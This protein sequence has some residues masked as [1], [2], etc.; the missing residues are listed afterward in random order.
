MIIEV[1]SKILSESLL[2]LYP[3]FVKKINIPFGLHLWCRFF[4]YVLVSFF[5]I[6][7]KFVFEHILSTN[8]ILLSLVTIMHVFFSYRGFQLL[9]SGI[10]Y[11][12]FYTYPIMILFLSGEKM[13]YITILFLF[14]AIF[15]IYLLYSSSFISSSSSSF[16][17]DFERKDENKETKEKETNLIQGFIMVFMAAFTEAAIYFVVKRIPTNNNWN[18]LFISYFFG[19]IAFSIYYLFVFVGIGINDTK[20]NISLEFDFELLMPL[21]IAALLINFIIGLFGYFLRFYSITRLP[22]KIYAGLSYIGIIMAFIYGVLFN[23]EQITL[24]KII[25]SIFIVVP[26][27]WI[28]SLDFNLKKYR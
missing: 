24:L 15:G 1:L 12:C 27:Y 21:L 26:V 14:M 2:S 6:D 4:I 5:F 18:H 3:I 10:A 7:W 19:A 23:Q 11:I 20:N 13:N 25:G 16:S 17:P 8:G 22:T 28:S 9:E